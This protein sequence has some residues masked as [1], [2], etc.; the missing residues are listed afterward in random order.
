VDEATRRVCRNVGENVYRVR[1]LRGWTQNDLAD[2]MDVTESE[3][4]RFEAGKS[5]MR[6]GT[7]VR[8]AE[9]LEVTAADL[10]LPAARTPK[11]HPG[12]PRKA[13]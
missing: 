5:E 6:I 12:R 10:L 4:R 2:R 11:R 7:L 3:V 9:A 1:R 13:E 8:L